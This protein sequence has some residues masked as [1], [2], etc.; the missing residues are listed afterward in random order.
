MMVSYNFERG[1]GFGIA[2]G[3]GAGGLAP[4]ASGL[5]LNS[6]LQLFE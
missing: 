5:G 3:S 6:G 1:S 2:Q 4:E